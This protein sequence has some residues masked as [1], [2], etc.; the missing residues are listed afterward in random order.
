MRVRHLENEIREVELAASG[1][2]GH[3]L[4]DCHRR[5]AAGDMR[6][7]I[8]VVHSR[9]AIH[10]THRDAACN[11]VDGKPVIGDG[12]S[13]A[14]KILDRGVNADFDTLQRA[15][16]DALDHPFANFRDDHGRP[17]PLERGRRHRRAREPELQPRFTGIVDIAGPGD[18]DLAVAD[19]GLCQQHALLVGV[20]AH[21]DGDAIEDQWRFAVDAGEHDS[22]TGKAELPVGDVVIR[23]LQ[24]SEQSDAIRSGNDLKG[25][26]QYPPSGIPLDAHLSRIDPHRVIGRVAV[27]DRS[28]ASDQLAAEIGRQAVAPQFTFQLAR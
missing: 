14:R 16:L 6:L 4:S 28:G 11:D 1:R 8:G 7:Q 5:G 17:Y 9:Q 26:H 13:P 10:R 3:R 2:V 23:R 27:D 21:P 25:R 24:M 12:R 18:A 15:A 22:A 19:V 20:E